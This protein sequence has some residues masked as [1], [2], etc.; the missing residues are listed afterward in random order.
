MEKVKFNFLKKECEEKMYGKLVKKLLNNGYKPLNNTSY[1][2]SFDCKL[3]QYPY[4][5]TITYK[6][7]N[8]QLSELTIAS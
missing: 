1:K 2:Y 4:S 3:K 8:I 7:I 5:I 6:H